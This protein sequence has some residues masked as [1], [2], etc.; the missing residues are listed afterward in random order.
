MKRILSLMA[1]LLT[2]FIYAQT[3]VTGTVV[4]EDNTPIPG[5]NIV[6]DLTTGAVSNFDGD[7]TIVVN[8]SPP[9]DLKV[10]SIGFELSLIHI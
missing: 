1:V 10:S 5:A 7:F 3:T 9:F 2:T 6:F 4:A 8:A